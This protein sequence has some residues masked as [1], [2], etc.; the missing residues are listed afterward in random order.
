MFALG[1]ELLM[2]R[3]V[4]SRWEDREE[5]EWPPHPD[6][7]F[8]ALVAAWGECGEDQE[9]RAALE[10]LE[11]EKVG[12]PSLRVAEEASPRTPFTSFVPVNDTSEPMNKGKAI[13]PMGT[14][15]IGRV[16][17][18]RQFPAVVPADP[19][20]HLV[21]P[22]A[23][24]PTQHR[25]ALEQLCGQVTYLGHSATPVR[26]W[27]EVNPV[28]PDLMP[29]EGNAKHR[30]RVFGPGRLANLRSRYRAGV[31]PTPSLW[32]GYGRP[33]SSDAEG[34]VDGSFDPGLIV[35]RQVGGRRFSLESCGMIAEAL[36]ATLMERW[37]K[38][39]GSKAPEWLSGHGV[40]NAPSKIRRP[41][42]IPFGFVGR[43]HA[44]GHLLGVGIAVPNDF[45]PDAL[46]A[47]FDLLAMYRHEP[48]LDVEDGSSFVRL[49]VKH[50]EFDRVVGECHLELDERG[51][52]NP[53][54]NLRPDT[55]TEPAK[56]W[57]TATPLVLPKFARRDLTPEAI[58][59]EA[60]QQAGYPEPVAVRTSLAGVL[61]GVPH[62]RSFHMRP[63][64]N[65]PPRIL[66]HAVIDFPQAV[67]G[68]VLI[69]GGRYNGYGVCR[70]LPEDESP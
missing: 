68:P 20:F 36:R 66:T 15:P 38:A 39:N 13:A 11:S 51:Q 21:W 55:W 50:P 22:E 14:M 65:R 54:V 69:G 3:A 43:E 2:K 35:L 30:L 60:C 31:R 4:I 70:P 34:I 33:Q 6:R 9:Q 26:M 45:P 28:Q 18:P 7:V 19:T 42:I 47:V 46:Q 56:L 64:D 29:T 62:A 8:M 53:L 61:P 24:L 63:R 23:E 37:T 57:A 32:Q 41:A 52:G 58:V 59:A 27:V 44:D 1:V 10:W 16:R 25:P 12:R 5:P 40:S 49:F 67:R 17:Q 48:D